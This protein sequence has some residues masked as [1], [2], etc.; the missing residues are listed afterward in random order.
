MGGIILVG[1]WLILYGVLALVATR[2]PDWIVPVAAVLV[3]LSLIAGW[4]KRGP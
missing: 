1:I 2:V 4:W 3:G